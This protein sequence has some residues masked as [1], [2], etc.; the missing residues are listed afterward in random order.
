M[1]EQLTRREIIEFFSSY[2]MVEL[3]DSTCR[4]LTSEERFDPDE[5]LPE[6]ARIFQRMPL[7]SRGSSKTGRSDPH[8]WDG[9]VFRCPAGQQWRVS[10]DGLDRLA[11]LGRLRAQ[12]GQA[13]LRW[14]KYEDEV[15]GRRI[16][17]IW[18]ASMSPT[19]K[20]YVVETATK[21]IQRCIL[22]TTD[23]GDL[24]FDPTCGSGTAAYV[25]EQWGRRWITCDT[26]RVATAL[27]KQRL[28]T[29]SFDYYDLAHCNEGVGSGLR[30]HSVPKV[31]AKTLAY[32][33]AP[34]E[35]MLYD[36][37]KIDRSKARVTGPFTVEAV[38]APSVLPLDDHRG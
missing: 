23:P 30:Y 11:S 2:A 3:A 6:G 33:E 10:A 35:V 14:K 27:A 32:D 19:G 34:V 7:I 28:M 5:Y 22:M 37:P 18:P 13:S 9:R 24:V 20:R 21:V 8:Q 12:E 31:S 26:S 25:A 15:P 38:P 4:Q 29:A 17:N 16:H 36:Q 1:Y